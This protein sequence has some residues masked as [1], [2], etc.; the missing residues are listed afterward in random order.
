VEALSD[1]APLA[2]LPIF[3]ASFVGHWLAHL[4]HL[5]AKQVRLLAS[6]RA[7]QIRAE[8]G[9]GSRWGLDV[10]VCREMRELSIL[11]ACRR[12]DVRGEKDWLAAPNDVIRADYLPQLPHDKLFESYEKFFATM[13]K[14]LVAGLAKGRVG[15]REIKPGV[16]VGMRTSIAP[17]AVLEGP[18]WLGEGVHIERDAHIGPNVIME[19]RSWVGTGAEVQAS[20]MVSDTHLGVATSLNDSLA[21]GNLLVDW[22]TPSTVRV[23]DPFLLSCMRTT[24]LRDRMARMVARVAEVVTPEARVFTPKSFGWGGPALR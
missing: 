6:D 2:T 13:Q 1:A 16:W 19:D 24:P 5:G 22:K 14:A 21:M 17:G 11:E 20:Y 10:E 3:G 9:D 12:Y 8:V 15:V 4:A 18:C 7:D 23:L